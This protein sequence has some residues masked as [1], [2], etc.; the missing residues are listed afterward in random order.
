MIVKQIKAQEHI[1]KNNRSKTPKM[2]NKQSAFLSQEKESSNHVL[3]AKIQFSCQRIPDLHLQTHNFIR[4]TSRKNCQAQL[5]LKHVFI[6]KARWC[7]IHGMRT[8]TLEE[9]ESPFLHLTAKQHLKNENIRLYILIYKDANTKS[10][11][12]QCHRQGHLQLKD[13]S[14]L[15]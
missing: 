7:T 4:R 9:P 11:L 10:C 2:V 13:E 1:N 3:K 14:K 8:I 15:R 6:K 12:P 5:Y